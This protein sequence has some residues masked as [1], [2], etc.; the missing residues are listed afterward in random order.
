[1]IAL[2]TGGASCGKSLFAE[3]LCTALGGELVYLA[4]MRPYGE[5]GARRVRKHRAQRAG[6][7]FETVECYEGI[8]TVL[9]NDRLA[10]C[11]ALLECLGNVVANELFSDDLSEASSCDRQS[12]AVEIQ[13]QVTE[14]S[15]VCANLVI[16][17]NDVGCDGIAYPDETRLYQEVIGDV[18]RFI[19]ERADL[20]AESVVGIPLVLKFD[21]GAAFANEIQALLASYRA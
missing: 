18:T 1:M 7:G 20:V 3:R 5:E 19:S 2:V 17:G 13:R 10:G 15:D 8:D 6:K 4:A 9:S 14:L 12:A 11:T 21:G 16:V